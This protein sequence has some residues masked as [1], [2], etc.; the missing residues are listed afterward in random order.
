MTNSINE[1]EIR[2]IQST[3]LEWGRENFQDFPWRSS[4]KKIHALI[5]EIMLHKTRAEQATPI[6]QTFVER[7]PTLDDA[8]NEDPDKIRE[9]L[10]PLGLR[11]RTEKILELIK[12]LH[13]NEG[14]IP[15]TK[16]ELLELPGV[17][18]YAANAFLSFHLGIRAPITDTNA[19]RLWSR[20]FGFRPNKGTYRAKRF[21]EL[22]EKIT[23][24]YDFKEFN[25]AV[26]DFTRTICRA[27]PLCELCPLSDQCESVKR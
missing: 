14:V 17:G 13:I 16:E 21:L 9:L 19:V 18:H 23:P 2:K 20:I 1:S 11:W 26:L 10:K 27:K 7:Y 6:F 8:L 3:L 22:V 24:V 25:Y 4:K 5:A 12:L 15:N